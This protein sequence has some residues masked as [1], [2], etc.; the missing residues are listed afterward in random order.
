VNKLIDYLREASRESPA[1]VD[2]ARAW[3]GIGS[4]ATL[5]HYPKHVI[6]VESF[7]KVIK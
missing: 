2:R 3:S 5:V 7:I 6:H 4:H 1:I